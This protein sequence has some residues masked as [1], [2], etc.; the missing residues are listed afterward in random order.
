MLISCRLITMKRKGFKMTFESITLSLIRR[1]VL[2]CTGEI[3]EELVF[4]VWE[5]VTE[6]TTLQELITIVT[7]VC[8]ECGDTIN[9][10]RCQSSCH[11]RGLM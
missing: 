1:A 11:E 6:V 5:R 10:G 7:G 9:N 8:S 3:R 2:A 4:M